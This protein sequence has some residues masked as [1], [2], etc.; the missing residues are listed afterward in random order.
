MLRRLQVN[1]FALMADLEITFEAGL[2]II[3]GE[4]GSGKSMI[5]E[6]IGTLCGDRME[7]IIIRSSRD[8]AEVTGVF[9]V[10]SEIK[11]ILNEAGIEG[12][13]DLII[14]RRLE[15]GKRQI[16]YVNDRVASLSLLKQ[17]SRNLIDL[18]GQHE[19]QSLFFPQNHLA[20]LDA[21]CEN[22]RLLKIFAGEYTHYRQLQQTYER[23]IESARQKNEK[24]DFLK[25]QIDEIIKADLQENEDERLEQEKELLL[26]SEKRASLSDQI[27][28]EMYD[29]E[30]AALEKLAR[31][32]RLINE[33]ADLDPSLV[34]TAEQ[35]QNI[36]T[37]I[38]ES[39]RDLTHYRDKIEFS[40]DRLDAVMDRLDLIDRL[41]KKYSRSINDIKKHFD[42]IKIELATIEER[43]EKIA[44]I[45]VE[46]D[47]ASRQVESR[48]KELSKHRTDAVPSFNKNVLRILKQLGM[49]KAEFKV[50]IEEGELSENGKDLAEFYIS[51]NPGEPL[52][53]LRK[54][55]S[56]GEV[57][58]ITL[59]LKTILSGID[60][61]PT[62]VFDEVDTGIGGRIAEAV[63][64][65]LGQVSKHHQI[66]C[67]T[68]LPQISAY[69]DNHMLVT[70]EIKGKETFTRV[71]K[72]DKKA[73]QQE[74][75]RM[76][77]GKK[78]T[79]T[80]LTH[81]EEIIRE[82]T[83]K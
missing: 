67:I 56:G 58:R 60:R 54:I 50:H 23:L 46:I 35:L 11:P 36:V 10:N 47:S 68:H 79:Q 27:I 4:T 40:Q 53:P 3:T 81:A 5:V 37:L 18:I 24:I 49:E 70:K 29:R 64:D 63:G 6:A 14:R 48:A 33:L 71:T 17:V 22:N 73:R 42:E 2:T 43:D 16:A 7:D 8:F 57:S 32:Y 80:T 52:K 13:D 59:A 26:S 77:G 15:K 78:I 30:D 19:N 82:K 41:K 61:I 44:A 21:F 9:D 34:K 55:A 69:A 75:A 1:N 28:S 65:L 51:T 39:H 38:D 66:I 25:Y 76:L 31:S 12:D 83:K 62:V 45:K 74:V 20:L 72:L